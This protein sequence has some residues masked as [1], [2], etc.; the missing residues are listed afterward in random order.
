MAANLSNEELLA[1]LEKRKIK[2]RSLKDIFNAR[3]IVE[4]SN[5]SSYCILSPAIKGKFVDFA[6][7]KLEQVNK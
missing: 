5:A 4:I 7:Q 6:R 2:P 3:E 1:E